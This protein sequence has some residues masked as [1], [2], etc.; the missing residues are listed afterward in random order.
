MSRT[1]DKATDRFLA[2]LLSIMMVIAALPIGTLH[3]NA[4]GT[5]YALYVN[6]MEDGSAVDVDDAA[7]EY[8]V[9]IDPNAEEPEV[10]GSATTVSGKVDIDLSS[11]ADVISQENPASMEVTVSKDGYETV[12]TTVTVYDA[13]KGISISPMTNSG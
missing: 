2:I 5:S 10:T 11:Y 8:K 7:V 6:S 1:R 4:A 9:T 12:N 3:V 13:V